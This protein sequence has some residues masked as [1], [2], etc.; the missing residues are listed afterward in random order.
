MRLM[1]RSGTGGKM[2]H[3][4]KINKKSRATVHLNREHCHV[5]VYY[6]TQD[7]DSLIYLSQTFLK[8]LCMKQE[9]VIILLIQ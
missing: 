3:E 8:V 6:I 7:A 4:K 5:L 9:I 2:I 1:G